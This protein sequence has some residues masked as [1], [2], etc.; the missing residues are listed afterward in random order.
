MTGTEHRL[1]H[2]KLDVLRIKG[3]RLL[4]LSHRDGRRFSFFITPKCRTHRRP[5]PRDHRAARGGRRLPRL[6]RRAERLEGGR[7]T[8]EQ[9]REESLRRAGA[10]VLARIGAMAK[11]GPLTSIG[12]APTENH[13]RHPSRLG[14]QRLASKGDGRARSWSGTT[15]RAPGAAPGSGT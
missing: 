3:A 11:T 4:K 6:E 1:L 14:A 15:A 10:M 9:V 5:G 2:R 13:P 12:A 7:M 8:A